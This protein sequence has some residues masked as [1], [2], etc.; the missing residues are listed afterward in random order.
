MVAAWIKADTGVGPAMASG[1]HI[2]KGICADLPVAPTKSAKPII[3][4]IGA[5][6]SLCSAIN[7]KLKK[8]PSRLF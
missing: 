3:V 7:E 1:N 2:Y 4:A 8:E 6:K 5:S